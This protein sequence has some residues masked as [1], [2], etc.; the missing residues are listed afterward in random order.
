[1]DTAIMEKAIAFGQSV[2]TQQVV[3][4]DLEPVEHGRFFFIVYTIF[5]KLWR[6]LYFFTRI[7]TTFFCVLASVLL[8]IAILNGVVGFIFNFYQPEALNLSNSFLVNMSC[9]LLSLIALVPI[10]S[11]IWIAFHMIPEVWSADE[12]P[13]ARIMIKYIMSDLKDA[14]M[15]SFGRKG[16]LC[17]QFLKLLT[18]TVALIVSLS[19]SDGTTYGIIEVFV[20]AGCSIGGLIYAFWLPLVIITELAK[21]HKKDLVFPDARAYRSLKQV[22]SSAKDS[23]D[24]TQGRSSCGTF[25]IG[26]AMIT[27]GLITMIILPITM[28]GIGSTSGAIAGA[29]I[30]LIV[31]TFLSYWVFFSSHCISADVIPSPNEEPEVVLTIEKNLKLLSFEPLPPRKLVRNVAL[32]LATIGVSIAMLVLATQFS[33]SLFD[34]TC[35]PRSMLGIGGSEFPNGTR[36]PDQ[37]SSEIKSSVCHQRWHTSQLTALDMA[38]LAQAAY[39]DNANNRGGACSTLSAVTWLNDVY[40]YTQ[41]NGVS[42]ADWEVRSV[43]GKHTV[44]HYY[45]LYSKSR[46]VTVFVVRGELSDRT[47]DIL[48]T[49][50]MYAP[51]ACFQ[52]FSFFVPLSLSLPASKVSNLLYYVSFTDRLFSRPLPTYYEVVGKAIR[53]AMDRTSTHP[54]HVVDKNSVYVVGH[55]LGGAVAKAAGS[56]SSINITSVSFNGP[57]LLFSA[58]SFGL[59]ASTVE[60][61]VNNIVVTDNRFALLLDSLGGSTFRIDCLKGNLA[62]CHHMKAIICKLLAL[63]GFPNYNFMC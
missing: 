14:S 2:I 58:R 6:A 37:Y 29:S 8:L 16:S 49:F 24:V 43:Y 5:Y 25:V 38:F 13:G 28:Q 23:M 35:N 44:V 19:I 30:C 31:F 45:E 34:D 59:S 52:F 27:H 60:Q 11:L 61:N 57:G 32:I 48:E 50:D 39:E 56:E 54:W 1:M 55:G 18:F 41:V 7:C 33:R 36:T 26:F 42:G 9:L 46:Q 21:Y 3:E 47:A 20:L 62:S 51:A 53:Q 12:M 15:H 17:F 10:T 40:R 22:N 63:C 4:D